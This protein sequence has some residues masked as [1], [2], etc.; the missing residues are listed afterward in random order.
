MN[1]V[2]DK[3]FAFVWTLIVHGGGD[4]VRKDDDHDDDADNADDAD[5]DND[6]DNDNGSFN[7]IIFCLFDSTAFLLFFSHKG[8]KP[9]DGGTVPYTINIWCLVH[10]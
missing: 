7:F 4:G 5:T 8:K 10:E 3:N 6:S 2:Y 9:S 1:V